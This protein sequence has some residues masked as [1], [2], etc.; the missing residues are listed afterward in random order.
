MGGSVERGGRREAGLIRRRREMSVSETRIDHGGERGDGSALPD[1]RP[2][3]TGSCANPDSSGRLTFADV[4]R[5][6]ETY[7]R[8]HDFTPKAI[9]SVRHQIRIFGRFLAEAGIDDV[10]RVTRDSMKRFMAWLCE[11]TAPKTKRPYATRS[12]F[13]YISTVKTT[14]AALVEAGLVFDDVSNALRLPK[15]P[16]R[17]PPLLSEEETKE[18][19]AGPDLETV[20]GYRDRTML[21][22][23]YATLIRAHEVAGLVLEDVLDERK[24]ILIRGKRKTER[25]LP[26]GK[27]AWEFL[28]N[29]RETM[30]PFLIPETDHLFVGKGG[31][32]LSTGRVSSIAAKYLDLARFEEPG[33]MHVLRYAGATHMIEH[34]ADI[35][36]VQAL[37]G[38]RSIRTTMGYTIATAFLLKKAHE[39]SHPREKREA[40]PPP[41]RE[42]T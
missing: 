34:G 3:S 21:E 28:E 10:R 13:G 35:R 16:R 12:R 6:L 11:T 4:Q 8:R 32:G 2:T 7:S 15:L 27:V 41:Y 36:E 38:H 5:E 30:R 9:Q 37:L 1:G 19:L 17:L 18:V 23:V 42:R 14:Y 33:G 20:M 31:R 25:V 29:Y 40:P 39:K 24:S 26:V 22:L